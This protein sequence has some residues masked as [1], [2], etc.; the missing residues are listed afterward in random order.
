MPPASFERAVY[1]RFTYIPPNAEDRALMFDSELRGQMAML[2]GGRA[3]EELT[4]SQVI[5]MCHLPCVLLS[6][7]TL[8]RDSRSGPLAYHPDPACT[9]F[10]KSMHALRPQNMTPSKDLGSPVQFDISVEGV[11]G[12]LAR[13]KNS[14][15]QAFALL[16]DCTRSC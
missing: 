5:C 3:A 13:R 14:K 6:I 2:M 1:C 16:R 8:Q 10:K 7:A 15:M 12:G 11:A 9:C 4:C